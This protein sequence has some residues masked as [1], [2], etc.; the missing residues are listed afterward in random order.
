MNRLILYLIMFVV[1]AIVELIFL[2]KRSRAKQRPNG[3]DA[4]TPE[5]I[6]NKYGNYCDDCGATIDDKHKY[7]TNCGKDV[8]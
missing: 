8:R 7:C 6:E 5:I 4:S 2:F 3:D 1:F